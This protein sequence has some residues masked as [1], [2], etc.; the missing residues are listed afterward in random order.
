MEK[1]FPLTAPVVREFTTGRLIGVGSAAQV[2]LLHGDDGLERALKCFPPAMSELGSD[3]DLTSADQLR[4]EVR[5]LTNF[6]HSHLLPVHYVVKLTDEWG[7][8]SGLL[9]DFAAGGSLAAVLTCRGS[10]SPGETVTVLTPMFQVLEFLHGQGVTHGDMSLGNILFSAVGKPLMA[11]LGLA[12]IIGESSDDLVIGTEGFID[13]QGFRR[14]QPSRRASGEN[15]LSATIAADIYALCAVGWWRLFGRAPEP[16]GQISDQMRQMVPDALLTAL[17]SGLDADWPNRPDAH[18]LAH[19]IYRSAAAEPVDLMPSVHPSVLPQMLT[20]RQIRVR[21]TSK[22]MPNADLHT[23]RRRAK[24]QRER[25]SKR[26]AQKFFGLHPARVIAAVIVVFCGATGAFLLNDF[27]PG[28]GSLP[29]NGKESVQAGATAS[30]AAIPAD[31]QR[32]LNDPDPGQ[33][34]RGISWLRAEEFRTAN[35]E[36][37][38]EVNL[39]GSS[40][41]AIDQQKLEQLITQK[42]FLDGFSVVVLDVRPVAI[43]TRTELKVRVELSPFAELNAQREK[44][45][46]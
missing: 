19:E 29:G 7:G 32:E 14:T 26:A 9:M 37:L 42:H 17:I 12:R 2:W 27:L 13:P 23:G 10:L 24:K 35:A 36:L 1:G 34:I 30:A 25:F 11:D 33:A 28:N 15:S 4:R 44:V 31:R 20:R 3:R 22:P 16:T 43:D 40:A 46:V 6:R 39:M 41:M 18:D 45:K 5:I 38:K 8:V 21:S